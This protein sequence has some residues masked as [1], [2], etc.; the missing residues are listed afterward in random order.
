MTAKVSTF[1]KAVAKIRAA[2]KRRIRTRDTF[3]SVDLAS[4]APNFK[5]SQR[6][7]VVRTALRQLET[8]GVISSTDDTVYNTRIRHRVTVYRRMSR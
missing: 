4:V 5:G 3:S 8:E 1:D 2:V 6:G 7:A